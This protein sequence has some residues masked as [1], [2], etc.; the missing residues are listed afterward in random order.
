MEEYI[1]DLFANSFDL[2]GVERNRRLN[3]VFSY[4]GNN[5]NVPDAMLKNG[6]AIE[7]KKI[8][9]PNSALALNERSNPQLC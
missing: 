5:S 3:E 4:L 9:S 6:D 1:K 7:V 2:S 8:E